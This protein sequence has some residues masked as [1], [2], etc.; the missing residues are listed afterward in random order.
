MPHILLLGDS[1]LAA[2][3]ESRL[4][5]RG[6]S[7][8]RADD[9]P[10]DGLLAGCQNGT[11][12][13]LAC[14]DEAECESHPDCHVVEE[15]YRAGMPLLL[16]GAA[17]KKCRW[18]RICR[19]HLVDPGEGACALL[20]AVSE[21]LE[22]SS[23]PPAEAAQLR[24]WHDYAQFLSHELRT[25]LTAVQAALQILRRELEGSEHE[26]HL[27]LIQIALRNLQRLR[28][29]V[30]W[31]EDY[32]ATRVQ[33]ANP[34]WQEWTVT[35]LVNSAVAENVDQGRLVLELSGGIGCQVVVSDA[36]LFHTVVQQMLR[37]VHY[38]TSDPCF[39]LEVALRPATVAH[40]VPSTSPENLELVLSCCLGPASSERCTPQVVRTALVDAEETPGDEL[41]RLMEFTVS[42]E[43][44]HLLGARV[45]IPD[46]NTTEGVVAE[47]I[48]P[49]F[50]TTAEAR[51]TTRLDALVSRD[52]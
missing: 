51:S 15:L 8:S 10:L 41:S 19:Q 25:P 5:G 33:P 1:P 26:P 42:R 4:A 21:C 52:C 9:L 44:L 23:W 12:V 28:Q 50:P 30:T 11:V 27:G 22:A 40:P 32:L 17:S 46:G 13:V 45:T 38:Q 14:P 18:R 7:V 35:D 31:S 2:E 48:L 39:R 16:V 6:L 3:I 36:D 29:A 49:R 43:L 47:L 37:A 20:A 24:G 34:E